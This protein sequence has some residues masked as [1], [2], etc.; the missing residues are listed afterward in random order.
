M[1]EAVLR[2]CSLRL[3]RWKEGRGE[4]EQ[5]EGGGSGGERGRGQEACVEGG[6]RSMR[7]A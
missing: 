5:E 2:C 1:K 3:R 6:V 4:G 7:S